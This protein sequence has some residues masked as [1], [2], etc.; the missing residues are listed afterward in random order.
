M[1]ENLA[2]DCPLYFEPNDEWH[3]TDLG[4]RVDSHG[5]T[6]YHVLTS[7]RRIGVQFQKVF[8]KDQKLIRIQKRSRGSAS[9]THFDTATGAVSRIFES[10]TLPDGSSMMKDIIYQGNEKSTES[11]VVI[12]PNGEVVRRVERHHL[13]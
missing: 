3:Q 2:D 10:S 1:K 4:T 5:K 7:D 12:A 13:G 9:E 6:T 8:D 11:V